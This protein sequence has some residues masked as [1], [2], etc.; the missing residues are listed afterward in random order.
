MLPP[1]S[2]TGSWPCRASDNDLSLRARGEPQSRQLVEQPLRVRQVK[3]VEA[4]GEPAKDGSGKI[5]GL[6]LFTQIAPQTC[7]SPCAAPRTLPAVRARTAG[8]RS[9]YA[10][11]FDTTQKTV[12]NREIRVADAVRIYAWMLRAA[13]FGQRRSGRPRDGRS[14]ASK[15]RRVWRQSLGSARRSTKACSARMGSHARRPRRRA[16]AI[17]RETRS[18][19]R[20]LA[21]PG[22]R[23]RTGAGDMM[24]N[25][26]S[27]QLW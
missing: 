25:S 12:E 2:S 5:A 17:G 4:L 3:R 10:S 21:W 1:P 14:L 19:Q 24:R 7:S 23:A 20:D 15:G 13:Q 27:Y 6:L 16:R 9:K 8:A 26:N 11:A 22:S 18:G